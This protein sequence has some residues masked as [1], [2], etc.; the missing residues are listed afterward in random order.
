MFRHDVYVNSH[1]TPWI[2]LSM[3]LEFCILVTMVMHELIYSWFIYVIYI[4]CGNNKYACVLRI[5][6]YQVWT[7]MIK[8]PLDRFVN[9]SIGGKCNIKIQDQMQADWSFKLFPVN[10]F[11]IIKEY[12]SYWES[13]WLEDLLHCSMFKWI[14]LT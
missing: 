2:K 4:Y 6:E 14:Y 13:S 11:T 7:C 9:L 5:N 10:E 3:L 12:K 1:F 8:N